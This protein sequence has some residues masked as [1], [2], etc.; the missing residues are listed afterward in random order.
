MMT[1]ADVCEMMPQIARHLRRYAGKLTLYDDERADDLCQDAIERILSR[2]AKFRCPP[3]MGA[4]EAFRRWCFTVMHHLWMD[5][6]RKARRERTETLDPLLPGH[7]P[8]TRA[9]QG[10]VLAYR[11]IAQAVSGMPGLSGKIVML[12]LDDASTVQIGAELGIA[13]GTVK[14]RLHRARSHLRAQLEAQGYVVPQTAGKA[15]RGR[16]P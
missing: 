7:D 9:T 3:G 10:D 5:R 8:T 13:E 12:A 2:Y 14:S 4:E 15:K 6:L 16:Q 1:H 11:P